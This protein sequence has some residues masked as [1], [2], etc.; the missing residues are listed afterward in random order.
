MAPGCPHIDP[1]GVSSEGATHCLL[2]TFRLLN[3]E[4][5]LLKGTGDMQMSVLTRKESE[6]R[7]SLV[8]PPQQI[9]LMLSLPETRLDQASRMPRAFRCSFGK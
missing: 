5:R 7:P 3:Q 9:L 2:D 4:P 8:A 1:T 6:E